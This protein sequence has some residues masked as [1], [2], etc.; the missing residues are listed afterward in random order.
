MSFLTVS[1]SN[2]IIYI[3]HNKE[4]NYNIKVDADEGN[5]TKQIKPVSARQILQVFPHL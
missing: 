4:R 5:P 1:N 3:S 2:K